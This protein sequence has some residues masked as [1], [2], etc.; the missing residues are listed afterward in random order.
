MLVSSMIQLGVP[1]AESE[2]LSAKERVKWLSDIE[3][4]ACKNYFRNVFLIELEEETEAFHYMQVGSPD[5]EDPKKFKVSHEKQSAAFPVIFPQGGNPLNAQGVYPAPCYL[6]YEAHVNTMT[7]SDEFSKRVLLPRLKRTLTFKDWKEEALLKLAERVAN[8][9]AQQV[10]PYMTEEKQLGILALV[11]S[12]WRGC[13]LI[14]KVEKGDL[15][16]IHVRESKLHPDKDYYLEGKVVLEALLEA[17]LEEAASLGKQKQAVSTFS[18]RSEE[19]VSI[20]NK[21]WPWLS[22]TWDAPRSIYWEETDWTPGVKIDRKNYEAYL[23]AAQFLKRL[24]VPISNPILKEMFAPADQ[25]EAKKN[26]KPTSFETIYGIPIV[27]PILNDL[28]TVRYQKYEKMLKKEAKGKTLHLQVLAGMKESIVPEMDDHYRLTILYYSGDLTKGAIHIRAML[29]DIIPSVAHSIQE[30]LDE[31]NQT[32]L[33]L[34]QEA[35]GLTEKPMYRVE[36]LPS[37]LGNAYGSSYLWNVLQ[38]T[39]HRRPLNQRQVLRLTVKKLNELAN[40]NADW[41]MKQELTFLFCFQYFLSEYQEMLTISE[42]EEVNRLK[43]W[44]GILEDYQRGTLEEAFQ[45]PQQ[46]GFVSGL[47]LKQFG[48]AYYRKTSKDFVKTRVM[49]FGSRLTPEVIWKN[50]LLKCE[51]LTGKWDLKHGAN[52]WAVLPLLMLAFIDQEP[53][54]NWKQKEK[55]LFMTAFWA[56]YHMYQKPAEELEK[57]E[58][59]EKES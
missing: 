38:D 45:T 36:N 25:P 2:S 20:Y 46:I 42:K 8:I 37:L 27:L 23:Y 15:N 47:L 53:E 17:R 26:M 50:G 24:Q 16:L 9:L 5:P 55:D 43:E 35:F 28:P 54:K 49:S 12:Q 7:K 29:E 6:M 4:E 30:I 10:G 57:E 33:P 3:L 56:G 22:P 44:K 21:S 18:H 40:I 31:L 13:R 59:Q 11:S 58:E 14:D 41:E 51:E 52:Y 34:I 32:E 19:V 39:L 48:N 1:I